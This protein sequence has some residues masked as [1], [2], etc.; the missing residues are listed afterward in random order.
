MDKYTLY[1]LNLARG[2]DQIAQ[3]EFEKAVG[4]FDKAEGLFVKSE[5]RKV[6]P[7]IYRAISKIEEGRVSYSSKQQS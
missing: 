4:Y 6:E 7:Y 2:I 1:N 5:V 3:G